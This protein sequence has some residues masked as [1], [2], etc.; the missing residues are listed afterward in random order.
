MVLMS[1][2]FMDE[3]NAKVGGG[4]SVKKDYK[5]I[6]TELQ[7]MGDNNR[8]KLNEELTS[9][10]KEAQVLEEKSKWKEAAVIY[11]EGAMILREILGVTDSTF[12]QWVD[13]SSECLVNLANEY[14]TWKEVDRSSAAISVANLIHFLKGEWT[15][16][17]AYTEFNQKYSSMIQTGKTAS[18]SMW[19]PYDLVNSID[20]MNAE[21]LQRAESYTQTGLL[22]ETKV[23]ETFRDAIYTV[24]AA[25]REAMTSKLKLPNI[26]TTGALPKD[27]VFGE[28]F[29][30]EVDLKNIGEGDAKNVTVSI[31]KIDGLNLTSG[32]YTL[33]FESLKING[34][35]KFKLEF[36]C[37]SGEGIKERKFDLAG[38]VEYLDII[39]NRRQNPIG[40]YT[41]IVRAFRKA[42]EL[43]ESLQKVSKSNTEVLDMFNSFKSSDSEAKPVSVA[44]LDFYN[45]EQSQIQKDI[46]SGEFPRAEASISLLDNAVKKVGTSS[47]QLA[48]TFDTLNKTINESKTTI[49]LNIKSSKE[50]LSK[51]DKLL[52]DFEFKWK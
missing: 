34:N 1:K 7:A 52:N 17:P 18:Q 14:I 33:S 6:I 50:N 30:L 48:S 36:V 5:A 15:L 38:K 29:S 16:L 43:K 24:L 31:K 37:P 22:T 4:K 32:S 12:K 46:Q 11:F 35:K 40:P 19:I 44:F 45:A 27:I 41:I 21:F 20:Q 26:E 23:T 3:L 8:G 25:A 42:D 39:N 13:R 51:V 10:S 28:K 9:F 2:D 47:V 49:S